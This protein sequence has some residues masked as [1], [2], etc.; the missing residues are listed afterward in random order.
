MQVLTKNLQTLHILHEGI[1]SYVP[2]QTEAKIFLEKVCFVIH[3]S[4]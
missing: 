3:R 4:Q 2:A 1:D